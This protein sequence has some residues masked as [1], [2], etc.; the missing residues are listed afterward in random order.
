MW[1]SIRKSSIMDCFLTNSK[2]RKVGVTNNE[3]SRTFKTEKRKPVFIPSW[4][5]TYPW[6]QNGISGLTCTVC[7]KFD[8]TG[9]FITGCENSCK[10]LT[11]NLTRAAMNILM[12]QMMI[13]NIK[14]LIIEGIISL[15]LFLT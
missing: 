2:K 15:K 8:K 5:S 11:M 13:R 6:L 10:C 9:T 14:I 7:T 1:N 4:T 3:K 12:N